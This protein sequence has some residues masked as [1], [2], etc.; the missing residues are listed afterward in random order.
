MHEA[1]FIYSLNDHSRKKMPGNDIDVY[2]QPLIQELSELWY[3][4]VQTF[5][6]SKKETFKMRAA[7]M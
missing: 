5:D 1:I 4:G 7:L 3:D 2:L 6:S